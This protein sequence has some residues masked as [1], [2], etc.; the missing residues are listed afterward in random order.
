VMAALLA[1]APL[2]LQRHIINTLAGHELLENLVWLCGAY[3]IA[4]LSISGLKYAVNIKS[5]GL[6]EFMIRSLRQ[7]IFNSSS[8]LRSD[9]TETVKSPR[10]AWRFYRNR[11]ARP[12]GATAHSGIL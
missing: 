9:A 3:L 1:M 4:A 7:D 6:G 11:I 12:L 2:E 8:P 10:A 5:A